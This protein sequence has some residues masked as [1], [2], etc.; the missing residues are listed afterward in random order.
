MKLLKVLIVCLMFAAPSRAITQENPS[1]TIYSTL[2][3]KYLGG[4]GAVFNKTPVHQ[5]GTTFCWKGFCGDLFGSY[6][7]DGKMGFGKEVDFTGWYG[8]EQFEVGVGYFKIWP[9]GVSDVVSPFLKLKHEFT[10]GEHNLM[11]FGK[12]ELYYPV[13]GNVP[14]HGAI[15]AAGITHTWHLLPFL[16]LNHEPVIKYDNGAFGNNP[17]VIGQYKFDLSWKIN[18]HLTVQ[19]PM[20]K[21]MTPLT[22]V[23]DGRKTEFVVGTG[24]VYNFSWSDLFK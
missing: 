20:L 1:I 18:K 11:L 14:Q 13:H 21:I 15:F 9:R 7:L 12:M 10:I 19:A 22:K 24:M 16:G 17:A 4:N 23:H 5:S 3:G 2:W 8:N 6:P